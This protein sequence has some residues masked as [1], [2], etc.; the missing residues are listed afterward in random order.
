[1]VI[2]STC[3][4]FLSPMTTPCLRLRS[5]NSAIRTH[6]NA[7]ANR[8]TYIT[9][10]T[11]THSIKPLLSAMFVTAALTVVLF[12]NAPA[13]SKFPTAETGTPSGS[14]LYGK[15]R[16]VDGDT[17]AFAKTR[18]RLHALDAPELH[19]TCKLGNSVVQCGINAKNALQH[20]VDRAHTVECTPIPG[21]AGRDQFQRIVAICRVRSKDIGK[22][23]VRDGHAVADTRF[24]NDY[25]S[26][27]NEAQKKQW[28]VVNFFRFLSRLESNFCPSRF[29]PTN[30]MFQSNLL[31][32]CGAPA[33]HNRSVQW[34]LGN[35]IS[36][37]KRLEKVA[38]THLTI[39][40]SS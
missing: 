4:A 31:T 1:M 25:V 22:M 36:T 6:T 17:L 26:F 3:I 15:P 38:P 9:A 7:G 8:R 24:G 11:D 5:T 21:R 18:V 23:L 32:R 2:I 30:L 10:K 27:E 40:R 14:I 19:Q 37:A 35:R 39:T 12:M 34:C 33:F 28:Y 13:D 20:I 29:T 16:V